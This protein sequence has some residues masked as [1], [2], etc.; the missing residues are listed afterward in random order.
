M[1]EIKPI[2]TYY[3][4]DKQIDGFE[5]QY[6]FD[7]LWINTD[8]RTPVDC[9]E[10]AQLSVAI[11][12]IAIDT[13]TGKQEGLASALA[14]DCKSLEEV[15]QAEY[16]LGGKY[17]IYVSDKTNRYLFGDATCSIQICYTA[18][19]G[20][21]ECASDPFILARTRQL[22]PDEALLKI[23]ESGDLAQAMPYDITVFKEIRQLLPNH[24]LELQ[25]GA[26]ARYLYFDREVAELSAKEA[27][28]ELAPRLL[29]TVKGFQSF[30]DLVIPITAGKDS[31]VVLAATYR[32]TPNVS[33]Y[34]LK[35][36][37][38]SDNA[39]DLVI[40][41]QLTDH[42]GIRHEQYADIEIP[43]TLIRYFDTVF[44]KNC[45][46]KNTLKIAATVHCYF[47]DSAIVNGDIIGQIGKCSLHRDIPTR[48][49]TARY[50]RCKMHNFSKKAKTLTDDWIQEV[51][52]SDEHMSIFDLFSI[53]N[54]MGRWSAQN[55]SLYNYMGQPNINFF[56]SRSIIGILGRV[57]RKDRM[58]SAI[59][60]ELLRLLDERFLEIPFGEDDSRMMKWSKKN[61][62]NFYLASFYKYYSD[63]FRHTVKR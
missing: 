58:T 47:H 28:V 26:V 33:T 11:I 37:K 60:K 50:F 44:G 5:K 51:R 40:A 1:D 15:L 19:D 22:Q 4:S 61:T 7:K 20:L 38:H 31:R 27:A 57:P 25:T 45:Y 41:K 34:T 39:A 52:Q 48:L 21:F 9:A 42:L 35:H 54:R 6:Q 2:F 16:H 3:L 18:G 63:K 32:I 14:N 12:G 55:L 62:T 8:A 43:E 56:N 53:E 49:A 23:R 13:N 36:K 30:F 59:H 46:S 29:A 10:S 24:T 17:L